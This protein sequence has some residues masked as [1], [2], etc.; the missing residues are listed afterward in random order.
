MT[1]EMKVDWEYVHAELKQPEMLLCEFISTFIPATEM[2]LWYYFGGIEN[3]IMEYYATVIALYITLSFNVGLHHDNLPEEAPVN[4]RYKCKA[5]DACPWYLKYTL[6]LIGE[7]NHYDHHRYPRRALHPSHS[8]IDL[9][10]WALIWPFEKM[11]IFYNV[12]HDGRGRS[13]GTRS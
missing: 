3:A 12:N 4:G 11:G 8:G 10:Y 13:K 1:P 7:L 5:H 9:T 2:Y 6:D